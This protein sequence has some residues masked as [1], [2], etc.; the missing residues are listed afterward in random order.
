[1]PAS[2]PTT[3]MYRPL[4][5]ET[6][7]RIDQACFPKS[8]A[9]GRSELKTMFNPPARTACWPKLRMKLLDLSSPSGRPR[10]DTS[11][12]STCSRDFAANRLARCCSPHPNSTRRHRAQI[13]WFLKPQQPTKLR[14]P[15]GKSMAIVNSAR[16]KTIMVRDLTLS[17][18]PS[19]S[20][21]G[22]AQVPLDAERF[23]ST[24]APK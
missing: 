11:S 23:T 4:D 19:L 2:A 18:C 7:Y 6:L 12:H 5:L 1:M 17:R 13:A 24:R 20:S 14:L 3:R 21:A 16:Y 9:Y 10:G 15:C 22:R 8:I